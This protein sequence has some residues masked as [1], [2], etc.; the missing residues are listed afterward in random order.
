MDLLYCTVFLDLM[1]SHVES[2]T[3]QVKEGTFRTL[4]SRVCHDD[5]DVD[6]DNDKNEDDNNEDAMTMKKMMMMMMM[7][8]M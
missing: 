1:H 5:D 3:Y 8:M 6:K 4:N 2:T 7:M